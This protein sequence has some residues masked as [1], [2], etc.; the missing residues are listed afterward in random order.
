MQIIEMRV[1]AFRPGG[2]PYKSDSAVL[3]QDDPEL[4][5]EVGI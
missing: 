3:A 4:K 1:V 5:Y 2:E